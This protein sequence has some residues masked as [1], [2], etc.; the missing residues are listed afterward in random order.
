MAVILGLVWS[1]L[2]AHNG[3]QLY[4]SV[5]AFAAEN[6]KVAGSSHR[7]NA[8]IAPNVFNVSST[9]VLN[10][11]GKIEMEPAEVNAATLPETT[12]N[13]KLVGLLVSSIPGASRSL[14]ADQGKAAKTYIEGDTL[15]GNITLFRIESDWVIVQR[16]D[17]FEK[18]PLH[19]GGTIAKAT[20]PLHSFAEM[21]QAQNKNA[22]TPTP[23]TIS[24]NDGDKAEGPQAIYRSLDASLAALQKKK[25]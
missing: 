9:T 24:R 22:I 4:H 15:P 13:L 3:Q 8:A 10:L 17:Q 7:P 12:A 1:A 23:P 2:I 6:P 11:F 19:T 25:S 21:V 18:L 14:I 16:G 20:A 5:D